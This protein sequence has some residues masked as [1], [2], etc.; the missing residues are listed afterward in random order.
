MLDLLVFKTPIFDIDL[1]HFPIKF[2]TPLIDISTIMD[3]LRGQTAFIVR[4]HFAAATV[5]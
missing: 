1:I 3:S 5:C 2:F 4:R